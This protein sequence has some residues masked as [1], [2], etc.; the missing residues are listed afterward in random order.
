MYKFNV[1]IKKYFCTPP[2]L[3][4]VIQLSTYKSD[5]ANRLEFQRLYNFPFFFMFL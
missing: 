5:L 3:E 2:T 1:H 4:I